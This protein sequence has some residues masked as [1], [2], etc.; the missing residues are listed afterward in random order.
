MVATGHRL[1]ANRL[2][3]QVDVQNQNTTLTDTKIRDAASDAKKNADKVKLKKEKEAAKAAGEKVKKEG[4]AHAVTDGQF[5]AAST[6]QAKLVNAAPSFDYT[7][8]KLANGHAAYALETA[9]HA[10]AQIDQTVVELAKGIEVDVQKTQKAA[11]IVKAIQATVTTAVTHAKQAAQKEAD[12]AK[13]I[14]ELE[15]VRAKK[16]TELEMQSDKQHSAEKALERAKAKAYKDDAHK[17][18]QELVKKESVPMPKPK[19]KAPVK[20]DDKVVAKDSV[21][22]PAAAAKAKPAADVKKK[23]LDKTAETKKPAAEAKKPAAAAQLESE[24][25]SD[26]Y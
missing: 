4:A 16:I 12:N 9:Q 11:A 24:A 1:Q 13:K 14:S 6:V 20:S 10:K 3:A 19:A 23:E 18:T 25:D 15:K 2:A 22:A 21:K 8:A 26:W 5:K 7:K 17:K